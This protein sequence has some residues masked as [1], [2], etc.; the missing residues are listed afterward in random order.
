M[1]QV[2]LSGGREP[3]RLS[4]IRKG[5]GAEHHKGGTRLPAGSDGDRCIVSWL[6]NAVDADACAAAAEVPRPDTQ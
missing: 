1:A 4:L 5:R 6:R 3:E 2:V